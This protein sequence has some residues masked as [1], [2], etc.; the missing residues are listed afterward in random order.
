[1][2]EYRFL[3]L[4]VFGLAFFGLSA[5]PVSAGEKDEQAIRDGS[6]KFV[7]A[8]NRHDAKAIGAMWTEDGDYIDETGQVYSGRKAI[9][10]EFQRYFATNKGRTVQVYIDMIRFLTPDVAIVDGT[11]VVDPPPEGPPVTGRFSSMRVK[12]G[13]KWL[14]AA[15]RESAVEVPSNYQH[16]AAV[17]WLLGEWLDEDEDVSIRSSV[18]W[19]PNKNFLI[20][21]FKVKIAD[22]PALSGT[23]RIGWDPE[24]QQI[25]SWTFDSNGGVSEGFWIQ[26]GNRWIVRVDAVLR[27]GEEASAT[28]IHTMIDP[29]TFSWES[30][31]RVIDGESQPDIPQVR[32]IRLPPKAM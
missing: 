8:F 26:D 32:V 15:V 31:N 21:E 17:D 10:E 19:G 1:M 23:Q 28:N 9:V 27:D 6:N 3:F 14:V 4:A 29:D 22:R 20:R 13:G 7:D 18:R 12:R 11:S 24:R 30:R 2:K 16:L 5:A 25:K